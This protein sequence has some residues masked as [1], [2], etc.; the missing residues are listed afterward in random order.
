MFARVKV[1]PL[2]PRFFNVGQYRY[3]PIEDVIAAHLGQLFGGMDIVETYVFRVTRVRELEVDEDVTENLLQAMERELVKRRFEPAVRLEVEQDMSRGRGRPAGQGAGGRRERDQP[4]ALAAGPDRS[5]RDRGPADRPAQVP[6]VRAEHQ[7]RADRRPDL[8]HPRRAGRARAPP[9]RLVHHDRAAA[10]RGGGRR[11]AGAGDQADPVPDQ[12]PV[13]DR[14][15]ADRRGRGGQAG[16][17]GGGDQGAV[18]REGEH[19]LGAQAGGG[20]LPR[21]LRLRRLEDARQAA[22][23][24]SG[25]RPTAP[26][27]ATATSAPATT[28]RRRPASTRTSACSP[29]TRRSARTSP[30]CS[31]TS[32]GTAGRSTT[33]GCWSPPRRCAPGS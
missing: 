25:R 17:G 29:P 9:L 14:G 2:L 18:R 1:P 15:R 24:S 26:C 19:H 33:A 28:T 6:A 5:E 21:G 3:V 16:R 30:T 23:S 4:A 27:G 13:A 8:R 20:R 7:G 11:P 22:C 10:G 31:T 32:P 12:R